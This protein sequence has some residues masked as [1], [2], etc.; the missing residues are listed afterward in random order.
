MI[1]I[2]QERG[3]VNRMASKIKNLVN[4]KQIA[5]IGSSKL[6]YKSGKLIG[7]MLKDFNINT[8]FTSVKKVVVFYY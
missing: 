2:E 3:R 4:A 7:K 8:D 6:C 5:S 1:G